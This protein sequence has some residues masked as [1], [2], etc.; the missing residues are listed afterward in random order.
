MLKT[1]NGTGKILL[2]PFEQFDELKR[3]QCAPKNIFYLHAISKDELGNEIKGE[4]FYLGPKELKKPEYLRHKHPLLE[5]RLE[6]TRRNVFKLR[7]IANHLFIYGIGTPEEIKLDNKREEIVLTK[8]TR[9]L[10]MSELPDILMLVKINYMEELKL[11]EAKI[12]L[13]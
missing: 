10:H 12:Q 8:H 2:N 13:Y 11:R 3:Y 1:S 9:N 4:L 6:P 5:V 7:D